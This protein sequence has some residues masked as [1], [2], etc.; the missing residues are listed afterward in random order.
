MFVAVKAGYLKTL[1]KACFL[2]L[3][4]LSEGLNLPDFDANIFMIQ[5]SQN[6]EH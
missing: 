2:G 6:G 3:G 5:E 1:S 4:A